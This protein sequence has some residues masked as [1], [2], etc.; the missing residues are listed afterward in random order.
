MAVE[1]KVLVAAVF[2]PPT[3]NA[4]TLGETPRDAAAASE[5]SAFP[6]KMAVPPFPPSAAGSGVVLL[7]ARVDRDGGVAEARVIRSAPPFDDA[8]RA[9]L[10]EWR[11]RPARV[12]GMPAS[13]FVYVLF[14]FPVPVGPRSAS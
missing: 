7:E 4:P 8:A 6:L 5:E 9:A 12:R 11:F 13:T 14:G 3:L 2:R 10:K 1:T